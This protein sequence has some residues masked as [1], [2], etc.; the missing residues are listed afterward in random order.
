[1]QDNKRNGDA[2]RAFEIKVPPMEIKGLKEDGRINGKFDNKDFF[3]K[4]LFPLP[5]KV[6]K[7]GEHVFV[8][9]KLFININGTY[10]AVGGKSK[11]AL[12]RYVKINNRICA[13]LESDI[14]IS[15]IE[16]SHAVK[17]EYNWVARG[18]SVSYFDILHRCFVTS[19]AAIIMSMRR[20]PRARKGN[21]RY[22]KGQ[23][24]FG[25]EAMDEDNYVSIYLTDTMPLKNFDD[26]EK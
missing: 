7:V 11:I 13:C 20:Q 14:D 23:I 8:T 1:M 2:K 15:N 25:S 19:K 6:I 16:N 17:E 26:K 5:P 24:T 10:V 21:S 22:W 9:E 3:L 18:K 12:K 4:I